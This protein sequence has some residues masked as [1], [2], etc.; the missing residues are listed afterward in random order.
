MN[1]ERFISAVEADGIEFAITEWI[2]HC[3][4]EE[5]MDLWPLMEQEHNNIVKKT[6]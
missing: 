6:S 4:A 5:F 1:K 3:T 2:L